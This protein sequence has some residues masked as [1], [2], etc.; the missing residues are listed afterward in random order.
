MAIL[1]QRINIACI[2]LPKNQV[3]CS[4]T[5]IQI[6]KQISK[7][8]L[9]KTFGK[10]IS[11]SL[12]HLLYLYRIVLGVLGQPQYVRLGKFTNY[13]QSQNRKYLHIRKYLTVS[14]HS[15]TYLDLNAAHPM[16]VQLITLVHITN[17]IITPISVLEWQY[18]S[19]CI[20]KHNAGVSYDY[21]Q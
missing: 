14:R 6:W 20:C 12:V 4:Y 3:C 5:I 17:I 19:I 16:F 2:A 10:I 7:L 21:V 11:E 9:S 8:S 1:Q 13:M 18:D 15:R